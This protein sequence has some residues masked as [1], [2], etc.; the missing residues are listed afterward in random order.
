MK[1]IDYETTA[2]KFLISIDKNAIKEESVMRI[3]N[4]FRQEY[5][6]EE[7]DMEK[8]VIQ[9]EYTEQEDSIYYSI[10][11]VYGVISQIGADTLEG[12]SKIKIDGLDYFIFLTKEQDSEIRKYYRNPEKMIKFKIK[13][14][15]SLTS[16]KIISAEL[17]SFS[18]PK[19]GSFIDGLSS[20]SPDT[21]SSFAD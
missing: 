16:K 20:L 1:V 21:F 13:Q 7:V 12:K 4:W 18:V 17:I 14:K 10:T 9:K 8:S 15:I 5:L 2:D 19:K 6:A 3:I 11:N